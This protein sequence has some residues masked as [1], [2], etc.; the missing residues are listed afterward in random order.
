MDSL[1]ALSG[2]LGIAN[3]NV[4]LSGSGQPGAILFEKDSGCQ[5][6]DPVADNRGR[7]HHLIMIAAAQ[8]FGVGRQN[9]HVSAHRQMVA[10][11]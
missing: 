4:L 1:G 3:H 2:A 7:A 8:F 10:Q 5:H 9:L 11:G 6:Q